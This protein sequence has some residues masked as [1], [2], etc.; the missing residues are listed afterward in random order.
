MNQH[1]IYEI[2]PEHFFSV[3][4]CSNQ[5]VY[6]DCLFL[7]FHHLGKGNSFGGKK[8][9][10]IELLTDYF[11]QNNDDNKQ[12]PREKAINVLRRLKQCGWIFEEEDVNYEV[13]INFT[14]YTIPILKTL[15]DLKKREELEYLGYI[16]LI[17]SAV[18]NM[19]LD[20][21]S[22]I[23]DQVYHNTTIVMNKLK[24]LNANIKKYIQDLLNKKD[25]NDLKSIVD[26]LFI[27]YKKNIIDNHYQRLKTSENISKYRPFIISKFNEISLNETIINKVSLDLIKREKFSDLKKAKS[28][29]YDQIEYIISSFEN[30]D[31]IM[32]EIDKKNAK[33][34]HTSISKILFI[35]NNTQDLQGK[36][37]QIIRYYVKQ[38]KMNTDVG[39]DSLFRLFPQKY[40]SKDSLYTMQ[41]KTNENILQTINSEVS[42]SFEEKQKR[43]KKFLENNVYSLNQINLYVSQLLGEQDK[44]LASSLPLNNFVD[45]TK[46]ILVYMYSGSSVDY[47]I[48][49]LSKIHQNRGY[50]FYDFE[51]RGK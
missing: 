2:L 7:M 32:S 12:T 33:Y 24:S 41:D 3:L 9:S 20:S 15:N 46:L 49:K 6:A 48:A 35:V 19:D 45:Y 21:L 16:F 40:L 8:E 42:L 25:I 34:I 37:N 51:I 43:L 17:Y 23:L 47:K 38:K 4:A 36:I 39:E 27:D 29:I 11:N 44:I 18:K 1:Q 28:H 13:L 26:N 50:I 22:D 30:F 5:A 31:Q 10:I 14:Y